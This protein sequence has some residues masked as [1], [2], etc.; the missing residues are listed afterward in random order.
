MSDSS[1]PS[2]FQNKDFQKFLLSRFSFVM[3][4]QMIGVYLSWHMYKLTGS[5]LSLGLLGLSEII[6]AILLALYAGHIIDISDKRTLL[7]KNMCYYILAAIGLAFVCS[8]KAKTM[9][10]IHGVEYAIYALVFCTGIFRS[11]TGPTQQSIVAQLITREQLPQAI[12]MGSASWQTAAVVGPILAGF[13]ISI[14][15]IPYAFIVALFFLV[16]GTIMVALI[17]RLPVANTN[18][19]RTWAS[20]KE[21][22]AYVWKTKTLL[23]ALSVDM[24]AV[25]FGGAVAMLPVY[26]IDILHVDATGMGVLRAAQGIGTVLILFVLT[27]NPIKNN[28]GKVM[29]YNV[30]LF[31]LMVLVFAVSTNFWL[32]FA[33]LFL[34][35]VFDAVSMVVRSTILQLFVPNEMRGRVTSVNSIFINSSN[36][37]GQFESG[38]AA[39]LMGTVPSVFFGGV[40]TIVVVIVAWIK[41][42]TLRDMEY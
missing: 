6:P 20:V 11:F 41:S 7:L 24:F 13:L 25:F 16:L 33:A 27:R 29:L 4:T 10:G 39:N 9:L 30:A 5:K 28:H 12:T 32:S 40:M 19:Q 17:P 3:A 38:V 22:I 42:P 14:I 26:A 1:I 31:G 36:E 8:G 18:S 21:G 2:P 34:S 23:S 35:G 15:G 37:L